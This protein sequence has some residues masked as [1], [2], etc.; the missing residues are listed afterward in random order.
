M[1]EGLLSGMYVIAA[2]ISDVGYVFGCKKSGKF[3]FAAGIF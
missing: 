2:I 3:A 1:G